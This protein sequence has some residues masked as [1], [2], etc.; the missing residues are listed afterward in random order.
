M[1]CIKIYDA[2]IAKRKLEPV[3]GYSESHHILPRALGGD[4][5]QTNLVKLSAREHFIAHLLLA[6]TYG[7]SMWAAASFMS[8]GGV[9][10]AS[11]VKVSS[12]IYDMAKREDAKWKSEAY[13]GSNNPF[14]GK[15]FT[16][17]QL[18]KLCVKRPSIT[19]ENHPFYGKKRD[20]IIGM[21][22]SSVLTYKPLTVDVD[23]SLMN[24]INKSVGVNESIN[25]I[26]CRIP[27]KTDELRKLGQYYRGFLM[28]SDD[29]DYRGEKNPNYGNGQAISGSKNPMYG[30]EHKES[31]KAKISEKAKR[32]ITCPH[33]GKDG[34]IANMKRWHFNNCKVIKS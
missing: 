34:N 27:V 14:Y 29:M 7:G 30:K 18:K 12:R 6:K 8:R 13:I 15:T 23:Y 28:R 4:N 9:K 20:P 10:S 1:D 31:T 16:S 11:G 26:G 5:S 24:R 21:L 22:I 33:C 19:G 3:D 32:R 25:V 17:E 2:I